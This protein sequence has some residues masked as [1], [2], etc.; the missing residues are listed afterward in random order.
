MSRLRRFAVGFL[1]PFQKS[2]YTIAEMLRTRCVRTRLVFD[3]VRM[4]KN[5]VTEARAA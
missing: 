3:Y 1:T 4:T 2:A 5:S